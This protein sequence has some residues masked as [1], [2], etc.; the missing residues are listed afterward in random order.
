MTSDAHK[1]LRSIKSSVN[2][3]QAYRESDKKHKLQII[4]THQDKVGKK[5]VD[6]DFDVKISD[7]SGSSFQQRSTTAIGSGRPVQPVIWKRR[8]TVIAVSLLLMCLLSWTD[9]VGTFRL[10]MAFFL[11]IACMSAMD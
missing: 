11:G 2:E 3:L 9:S 6:I 7:V 10:W 1:S 8:S 4:L 5:V